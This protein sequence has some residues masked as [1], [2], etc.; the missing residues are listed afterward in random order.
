MSMVATCVLPEPWRECQLVEIGREPSDE[1]ASEAKRRSKKR[2]HRRRMEDDVLAQG[3]LQHLAL[4][5]P[6]HGLL[7]DLGLIA[8]P[9][10]VAMSDDVLGARRPRVRAVLRHRETVQPRVSERP[11]RARPATTARELSDGCNHAAQGSSTRSGRGPT[12]VR[13]ER[14]RLAPR[15]LS[16]S[17]QVGPCRL[18]GRESNAADDDAL[19]LTFDGFNTNRGEKRVHESW[20]ELKG[21]RGISGRGQ[22]ATRPRRAM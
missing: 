9:R 16:R 15:A 10:L 11:E 14:V 6:R 20:T 19:S 13:G 21:S 1:Q 12:R 22:P 18:A 7:D 8:L 17:A 2:T 4:E 3:H 5:Q